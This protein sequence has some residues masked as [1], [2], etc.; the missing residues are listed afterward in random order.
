[1]PKPR[2]LRKEDI[3]VAMSHTKSVRAAARYLN[4]S[5][6]HL[7]IW[8]KNYTDEETGLS[9][10]EKHKNP[11]G[12][13]IKKFL[14]QKPYNRKKPAIKDLL[15]GRID[16]SSFTPEK[17]KREML[18]EGYL[19]EECSNCGYCEHRLIDYKMPLL[20]A[21]KDGN[22]QHYGLGN[23]YMLCYNCYFILH[24]NVFTPRDIEQIEDHKQIQKT[25]KLVKFDLDDRQLEQLKKLKLDI[26]ENDDS[27]PYSLVSRKK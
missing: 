4:C 25:T 2:P 10:F 19:K 23:I 11:Q 16:A 7:K 20:M 22:K 9:L 3:L 27:D 21:F 18:K 12:K 17:I 15:E 8:M 14:S 1:M 24:G 26:N 6:T 5:F 13:G